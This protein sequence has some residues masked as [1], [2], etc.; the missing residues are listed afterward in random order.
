M[1]VYSPV[2]LRANQPPS[3]RA[4]SSSAG[5]PLVI[6]TRAFLKKEVLPVPVPVP[7]PVALALASVHPVLTT[8]S[9]PLAANAYSPNVRQATRKR[10]EHNEMQVMVPPPMAPPGDMGIVRSLGILLLSAKATSKF[11]Y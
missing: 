8:P 9:L 2:V 6:F 7:V 1:I 3:I 4:E 5:V 10:R 11:V